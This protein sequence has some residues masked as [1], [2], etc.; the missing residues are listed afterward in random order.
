MLS[1]P[2]EHLLVGEGD[3]E[4]RVRGRHADRHHRAHEARHVERG[5]GEEE[6][7]D[8]ARERAGQRHD[9]DER[10]EP[11]LVVHDHEEVDEDDRGDESDAEPRERRV[12]VRDEALH[13][14]RVA[15]RHLRLILGDDLLD[16]VD[17]AAEVAALH[18]GEDVVD[19]LDVEMARGAGDVAALERGEIAEQLRLAGLRGDRR[20]EQ[21][22][23]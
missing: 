22:V 19:R 5:A 2:G 13:H 11:A 9:D 20:A 8:D 12:H 3:H 15:R 1:L 14:D 4:D 10:V 16:L 17:H 7:P 6:R 18:V 23:G 21:R